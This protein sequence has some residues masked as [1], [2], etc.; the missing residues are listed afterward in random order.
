VRPPECVYER[1]SAFT[2]DRVRS[3]ETEC[4]H[5]RLSAFV[6][7]LG[8]CVHERPSAFTR[9][10][11]RSRGSEGVQEASGPESGFLYMA[12]DSAEER[13]ILLHPKRWFYWTNTRND[14]WENLPLRHERT[15]A[16]INAFGLSWTHSVSERTRSLR[17]ALGLW[18]HSVSH[19]RTQ[20]LNAL[21]LSWT[22]SVSERTRSLNAL[23]HEQT[24]IKV[25]PIRKTS[26]D[27]SFQIWLSLQINRLTISIALVALPRKHYTFSN[28]TLSLSLSLDRSLSLTLSLS[29]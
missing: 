9:D 25:Y 21:G 17:N 1:P 10:E 26:R 22:H 29:P 24:W 6:G 2:R 11:G 4:I 12:S 23:S 18:T 7:D 14:E 28:L 16:L 3:R 5:E 20:S 8:E 15:R 19:E 13:S 27:S